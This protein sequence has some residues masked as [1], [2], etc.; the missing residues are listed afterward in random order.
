MALL[1]IQD[2][3]AT[4]S[5]LTR[6]ELEIAQEMLTVRD[7]ITRRVRQEVETYNA[8]QGNLFQGLVQPTDSERLLNGGGY[9]LRHAKSIDAEA[10]VYRALEAFQRNGFFL[11]VNDHQVE[12]LDEEVW[13]G[14]GATAG[15]VKLTPLV[16]G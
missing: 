9:R 6:L 4:G 14:A 8:A 12:D 10:Q 11:L 13:L 1:T 7:L 16:G 5:V 3:T 2:E 15:F